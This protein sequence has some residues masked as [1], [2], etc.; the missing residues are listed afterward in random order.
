MK[1]SLLELTRFRG[2]LILTEEGVDQTGR[3]E[4]RGRRVPESHSRLATSGERQYARISRAG[5]RN[6]GS[7]PRFERRSVR[8]S[9]RPGSPHGPAER[10]PGDARSVVVE[11]AGAACVGV[12]AGGSTFASC[13]HAARLAGHALG[14][15]EEVDVSNSRGRRTSPCACVCVADIRHERWRLAYSVEKLGFKGATSA[16]A[17]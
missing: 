17:C 11:R 9:R 15:S 14:H 16:S 4:V 8:S 3:T 6:S 2:H 1:R 12:V 7:I 5:S 10:S 13:R